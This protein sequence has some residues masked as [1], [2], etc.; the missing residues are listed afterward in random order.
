MSSSGERVE[1][2]TP[3]VTNEKWGL[4]EDVIP[5]WVRLDAICVRNPGLP[6]RQNAAGVDMTGEVAG[7]LQRWIPTGKG[8]WLG[9]VH[10][11]VR[12]VDQ[13]RPLELRNQL[14]PAYAL[15]KRDA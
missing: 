13:R 3:A 11:S 10:Y 4:T 9:L 8:D 12:Y 6:I 5:V 2:W 15:R 14:V 1:G 7:M